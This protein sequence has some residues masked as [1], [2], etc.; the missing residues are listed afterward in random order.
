MRKQ[1]SQDFILSEEFFEIRLVCEL[2]TIDIFSLIKYLNQANSMIQGINET[3]NT[4]FNAGYNVVEV[5]AYA[6][7]HGSIRIPLK[8]KKIAAAGLFT[9]STTIIG[10]VASDLISGK[11]DPIVIVSEGNNIEVES[12]VFLENNKTKRSV[13]KIAR[14]VVDND[15]ISNLS[16]TYGKSDGQQERLTITKETLKKVAEE[17]EDTDEDIVNLY[18]NSHLEI[19]GPI[20]DNKPSSWRVK[21]NGYPIRAYMSDKDFLDEMTAKKI[22]FAPGDEIVAD[23]EEVISEDEKGEHRNWIIKKVHSYPK[24]TRIIKGKQ[25]PTII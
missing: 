14:M 21:L 1:T 3:L 10:N 12:S 16:L 7:E 4:S 20:F 19:Y 17:C 15:S 5:E 23:L 13:G 18:Q 2:D 6:L 24:Y 11:N 9:I 22:A 25:P 8:L